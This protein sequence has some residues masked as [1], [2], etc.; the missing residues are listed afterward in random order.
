M[1][2]QKSELKKYISKETVAT[3]FNLSSRRIE[4]LTKDG[5]IERTLIKRRAQYETAPTI[6]RYITYLSDKA[7]NRE[8]TDMEKTLKEQK[9][10]AEIELKKSQGELHRLRTEIAIGNYISVDEIKMDYSRFFVIFKNFALSIPG[11]VA[12][13]VSGALDPVEVRRIE[14]ELQNDI[15]ALLN[16]FVSRAVTEKPEPKDT[17]KPKRKG[18]PTKNAKK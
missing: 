4:Q 16:G 7:Y 3:L 11:K 6:Q 18:R 10:R 13:K 12:G 1:A 9:L 14:G 8:I 2:E 15:T 17:E 5:I